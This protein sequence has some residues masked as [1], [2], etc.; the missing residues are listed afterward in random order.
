MS[1]L[2]PRSRYRGVTLVQFK[3]NLTKIK[4][5]FQGIL[6]QRRVNVI[7]QKKSC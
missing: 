2:I 3:L 7:Y 5:N 6:M 1:A 4:F